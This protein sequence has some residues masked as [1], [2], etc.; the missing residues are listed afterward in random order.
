MSLRKDT[1]CDHG[2]CPYGAEYMTSCE[3]WC[4]ADEPADDPEIWD[5]D[6]QDIWDEDDTYA[7]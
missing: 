3:Y 1:P 5:A 7:C 2:E 6:E 4:G